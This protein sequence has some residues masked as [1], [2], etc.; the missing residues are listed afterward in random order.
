MI[1]DNNLKPT[2][3]EAVKISGV[4]TKLLSLINTRVQNVK[5][6]NDVTTVTFRAPLSSRELIALQEANWFPSS[7]SNS[8][9]EHHTL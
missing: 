5:T 7:S 3:V 4:I 9:Y 8:T 2:L 6:D 1:G